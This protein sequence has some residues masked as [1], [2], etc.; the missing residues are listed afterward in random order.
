[1]NEPILPK[2]LWVPVM[3]RRLS[4]P[5]VL[6]T[7][8][9]A[10]A[11]G[12]DPEQ[13]YCCQ[14]PYEPD[15][16]YID[17]T[18]VEWADRYGGVGAGGVHPSMGCKQKGLVARRWRHRKATRIIPLEPWYCSRPLPRQYSQGSTRSRCPLALCR[19][20]PSSGPGDVLSG[21][22]AVACKTFA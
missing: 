6:W 16:L 15:D 13:V 10:A 18:R 1:M 4:K 17:Q 12:F 7:G 21:A 14:M 3:T 8:P 9:D 5:R 22:A 2:Q 11:A 20:T 19:S